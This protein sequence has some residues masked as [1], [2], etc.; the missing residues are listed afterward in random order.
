MVM[1][2]FLAYPLGKFL[3][4]IYDIAF[5]NYG[6]AIIVFTF[7]VRL[8]MLPLTIKQHKS[9]MKMQEIQPLVDDIRRKY[10]D[11]REAMNQELMKLYQEQN[12][13]PA[14]G[15]LP[16]L[17]QM[18]LL[19]T[20]YWVIIQPLKFMLGKSKEVIDAIVNAA[21]SA[22]AA[23]NSTLQLENIPKTVEDIIKAWGA[24]REIRALNFFNENPD[25]L[26]EAGGLLEKSELIDFRSFLGLHLGEVASFKPG[27]I[28]GPEWKTYLP[29]FLLVVAATVITYISSKLSMPKTSEQ[30]GGGCS[31]SGMMYLG[32]VMTLIYAFLLP[33][34]V[35][36][37]W[38]VGYVFAIFQ[39]L[40]INKFILKKDKPAPAAATAG[41]G[42]EPAKEEST[43]GNDGK[44]DSDKTASAEQLPSGPNK[45]KGGS[46]SGKKGGKKKGGK[47]KK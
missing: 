30:Q 20:L 24:H 39:Q 5:E 15:C 22:Q 4:F 2:D 46:G 14:G 44:I 43:E 23:I 29:L 38:M 26:S 8:A 19:L 28:F 21:A 34:G 11:D 1:F 12:Y 33:A 42:R 36:L 35:V 9:S 37:Y 6:L 32:P 45:K 3:K 7:I 10:K 27:V 18:P 17:I 40:Y 31:T 41:K 25:L 47:K 13:N 16:T